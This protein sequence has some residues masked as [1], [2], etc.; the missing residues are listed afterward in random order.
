MNL[1]SPC[2]DRG[3]GFQPVRVCKSCYAQG[4]GGRE[5]RGEAQEVQVRDFDST[6]F[7]FI[8][9]TAVFQVRKVGETVYGTV[10]SL[11]TALEF[12]I[13]V[14]KVSHFQLSLQLEKLYSRVHIILVNVLMNPSLGFCS[15]RVLGSRCRNFFLFRLRQVLLNFEIF[16]GTIDSLF[17]IYF[18]FL[19]NRTINID[20]PLLPQ[21][22]RKFSS[23]WPASTKSSPLPPGV[24]N[25]YF[26]QNFFHGSVNIQ[27]EII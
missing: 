8:S 15:T 9:N 11:A 10:T 22:N 27:F 12:P 19:S 14:L 20:T 17:L 16:I 21:T 25:V 6:F 23:R 26:E 4:E 2:P 18:P 24:A 3:W 1:Q 5:G 13:S 7:L